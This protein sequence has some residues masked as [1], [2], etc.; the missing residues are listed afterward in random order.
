MK[1]RAAPGRAAAGFTLIELLVV[2]ALIAI[3]SGA[4]QP[5]AARP[6]A[7]R[8]EEKAAR[9]GRLLES[10]RAEARASGL[11][12]RW[13]RPSAARRRDFRFVG[14]PPS[15]AL[16]TRWLGDGVSAEIVGARALVLGPEPLIGAQRVVLRLDDRRLV[17]ATDGLRRSPRPPSRPRRDPTSRRARLHADRGAGGAGHRGRHARRRHQGRRRAD[18]QR[19]APGRRDRRAVV[20]R[21]PAR[22]AASWRTSSPASATATS[23]ANSSAATS[24]ASCSPADAEPEL[25]SRRCAGRRRRRRRC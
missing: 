8:L 23:P 22:R 7:S 18:Q 9:L 15:A 13:A 24:R 21:Q 11:T 20:R 1:R 16:P 6:P 12:V 2:V 10:A 4:G 3:A 25:P 17:L 19:A 5:G 14:L